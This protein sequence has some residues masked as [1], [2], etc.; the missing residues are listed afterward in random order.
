MPSKAMIS[1]ELHPF[2]FSRPSFSQI[3]LFMTAIHVLSQNTLLI[4]NVAKTEKIIFQKIKK[5]GKARDQKKNISKK[6]S[7]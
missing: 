7:S 5:A 6:K 4:T 3:A 2:P 1:L